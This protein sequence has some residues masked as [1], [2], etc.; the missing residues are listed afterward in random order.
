MASKSEEGSRE[1][2]AQH[3]LDLF[4][5]RIETQEDG[6]ELLTGK[7][8]GVD[9][10]VLIRRIEKDCEHLDGSKGNYASWSVGVCDIYTS[11]LTL[12]MDEADK[13]L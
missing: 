5:L 7:V 6:D 3:L 13:D 10:Q 8:N 4:S 12:T 1:K 2:R 11:L 9:R